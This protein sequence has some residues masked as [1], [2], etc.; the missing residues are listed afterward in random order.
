MTNQQARSP[1]LWAPIHTPKRGRPW[2]NWVCVRMTRREA[3]R[4]LLDGVDPK[5]HAIHL[6][7]VRFA[8]VTITEDAQ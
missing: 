1:R 6:E 4:A 2:V 5:H 3:K 7:G 8:R